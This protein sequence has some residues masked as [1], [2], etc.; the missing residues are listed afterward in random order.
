[1]LVLKYFA[2]VLIF[3]GVFL[4]GKSMIEHSRGWASAFAMKSRQMEPSSTQRK[5]FVYSGR[6]FQLVAV[7]WGFIDAVSVLVL[8]F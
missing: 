3:C 2:G 7:I 1:M 8:V 4:L 5:I 6:I